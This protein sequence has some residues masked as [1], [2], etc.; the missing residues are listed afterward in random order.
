MPQP[1]N[2]TEA[3]S[4]LFAQIGGRVWMTENVLVAG[5]R[6]AERLV[7]ELGTSTMERTGS[8]AVGA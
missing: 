3:D 4:S 5:I 2:V 1:A 7:L 6:T 8:S